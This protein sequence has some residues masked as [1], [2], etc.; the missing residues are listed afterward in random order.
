MFDF[1]LDIQE[2]IDLPRIFAPPGEALEVEDG[3][4]GAAIEGLK[5]LGHDVA[6]AGRPIGGGQAIAIDWDTG[7]LTGGS[8]PRKDGCALGY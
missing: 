5:A 3:V 7:V 1:G 8:D 6:P 4:P 2:A